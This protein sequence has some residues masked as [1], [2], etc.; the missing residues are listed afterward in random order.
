[1]SDTTTIA[2]VALAFL[3]L[4]M[5]V[6]AIGW[7]ETVSKRLSALSRKVLESKDIEKIIEAGDKMASLES[8]FAEFEN[9]IHQSQNQL[10]ENERKANEHAATL[11]SAE[12]MINKQAEGLVQSNQS[13]KAMADKI[14]NLEEFQA[15]TEKFGNLLFAALSNVEGTR[16]EESLETGPKSKRLNGPLSIKELDQVSAL[17]KR[18]T[19]RV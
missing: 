6:A 8:R 12:Q 11:E 19:G 13:M 7:I 5:A 16:S 1:M 4:L 17:A 10:L 14:Q 2:L 15:A 18:V 9:R 3:A